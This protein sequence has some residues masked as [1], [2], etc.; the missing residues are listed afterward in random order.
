MAVEGELWAVVVDK[1]GEVPVHYL[2]KDQDAANEI[3]GDLP[4]M[5]Q[6]AIYEKYIS[7]QTNANKAVRGNT[8]YG[9]RARVD[10]GEVWM[11]RCG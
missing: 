8:N 3:I 11:G 1:P 9:N 6:D 4:T 2:V 7:N 5:D 10:G